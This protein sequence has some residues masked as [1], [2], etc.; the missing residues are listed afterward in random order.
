MVVIPS[1]SVWLDRLG[2]ADLAVLSQEFVLFV[3]VRAFFKRKT[4]FS[5]D[6][7]ASPWRLGKE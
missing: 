1:S 4:S 7:F 5:P 2:D 6:C 3:G